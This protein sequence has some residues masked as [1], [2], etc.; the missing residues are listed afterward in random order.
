MFKV[1]GYQH[2]DIQFKDGRTVSGWK[3]HLTEPRNGVTGM[4]ADS[5]FISDQK[6]GSYKPELNQTINIQWNRWGKI[7][8]ISVSK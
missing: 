8:G 3:L 5:I 6:A 1:V 2:Q 7:E 4:A